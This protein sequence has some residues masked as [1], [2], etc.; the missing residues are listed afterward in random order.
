MLICWNLNSISSRLEHLKKVIQ[1]NNPNIFLLQEIKCINDKF[2]YE[3]LT[4]LG[5]N[6]E[7]FGQKAYNG[8]AILSKY[9]MEDVIK[10]LESMGINQDAR[11]IEVTITINRICYKVISLYVPNGNEVGSEKFKYKLDFFRNLYERLSYLRNIEKNIIIGG[12]FNVAPEEIDL[13]NPK[14]RYGQ[15]LFHTDERKYFR[16]I[17]NLGYI[18]SFREFNPDIQQFS[19]WDYR[20]GSWQHNKGMRIDH[21]LVS[22]SVADKITKSGVLVE[23]RGWERSSDHAPIYWSFDKKE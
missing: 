21:I 15:I 19:W 2:P 13:Y 6:I 14:Q 12:D 3:E 18:D 23:A 5:Y 7:I 16:K 8:V 20:A 4:D 22:P 1:R 9:P 11:Y 10:G 17:L